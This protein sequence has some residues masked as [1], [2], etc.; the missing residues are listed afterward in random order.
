[1]MRIDT[2]IHS[3]ASDGLSSVESIAKAARA[4]GLDAIF[5]TDHDK[6]YRGERSLFGVRILPGEEVSTTHGHILALFIEEEIPK[7]LSPEETIEKIHE[8]SGIAIAAHPFDRLRKGLGRYLFRVI[9]KIDAIEINGYEL[10]PGANRKA[11][12][13]AI[14]Y[15]KP[16]TAGTDAHIASH[17]GSCYMLVE[18]LSIESLLRGEIRCKKVSLLSRLGVYIKRKKSLRRLSSLLHKEE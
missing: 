2:H 8:A 12:R 18:D 13:V 15:K 17:V 6:L 1:M 9:D 16:L 4:R 5:I 11:R 3:T 14:E 7:G 10:R